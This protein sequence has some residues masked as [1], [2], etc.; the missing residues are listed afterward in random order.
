ML[1]PAPVYLFG[2]TRSG[3]TWLQNMLG[4]HPAIAT[5]QELDLISRY[6]DPWRQTWESQLPASAADWHRHRYK[7]LPSILTEE[8]F[9]GIVTDVIGRIYGEVLAAKP[10]ATTVLEKVPGYGQHAALIL[11]HV[12]NARF[13]HLIR[14]GRDVVASLQR[15]ASG[16]GRGWAPS[17]A[18]R[19]AWVWRTNVENG[20][21]ASR[22]TASYLELRYEA[23]SSAEGPTLLHQAFAF[24]GIETSP[25]EARATYERFALTSGGP[26]PP[27]SIVWGGEVRRRIGSS[28]TAE[29]EGFFGEGRHGSWRT[30]LGAFDRWSFEHEAGTLLREL[31]YEPDNQ[32]TSAGIWRVLGPAR[33]AFATALPR[34]RFAAGA[35]RRIL[36]DRPA[37]SRPANSGT[38]GGATA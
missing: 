31:G 30:G 29:P 13:I 9:D 11:R 4:S 34:L 2:A 27:S 1:E 3:T 7:G 28:P 25:D 18:Q 36:L 20:R 17:S 19:G 6:V 33:L 12:P 8:A 16:W 21:A 26:P 38:S 15:A 22:L 5:P 10:T 32:W 23:L 14:D 35:A 24:C 37:R